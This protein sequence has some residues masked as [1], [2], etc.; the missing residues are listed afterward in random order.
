MITERIKNGSKILSSLVSPGKNQLHLGHLINKKVSNSLT[1]SRIS[2]RNLPNFF[3][4]FYGNY[5]YETP[6]DNSSAIQLFG[7]FPSDYDGGIVLTNDSSFL[8]FK[9]E[10]LSPSTLSAPLLYI[11]LM[12]GI[13]IFTVIVNDQI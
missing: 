10:S 9:P 11:T 13:R 8:G 6:E 1:E 3:P 12:L 5:D 4:D 2:N 7:L